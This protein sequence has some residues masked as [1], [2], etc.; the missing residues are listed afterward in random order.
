LI[1]AVNSF[2]LSPLLILAASLP[3]LLAGCVVPGSPYG[4]APPPVVAPPVVLSPI[5]YPGYGYGYWYGG[6]F[7]GYRRGYNFHNGSYYRGNYWNGS[8][9]H[10]PYNGNWRGYRS[11]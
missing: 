9:Y 1:K 11:Y 2:F 7:C 5:F 4:Y 8:H 6:R 10:A 3:L